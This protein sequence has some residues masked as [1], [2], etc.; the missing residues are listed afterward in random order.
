MRRLFLLGALLGIAVAADTIPRHPR[1]LR[2]PPRDLTAPRAAD[3]RHT[4]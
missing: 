1:E 4:L 3:Y 2:Y